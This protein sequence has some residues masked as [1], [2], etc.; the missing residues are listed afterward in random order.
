LLVASDEA[1]SVR[2]W[3]L[4][5]P[6]G[7]PDLRSH[8]PISGKAPTTVACTDDGRL[9]AAQNRERVELYWLDDGRSQGVACSTQ[10]PDSLLARVS[11]L[12][13]R[14]FLLTGTKE[15]GVVALRSTEDLSIVGNLSHEER[16]FSASAS[17]KGDMVACLVRNRIVLWD[18][19][20]P[21]SPVLQGDLGQYSDGVGGA[22]F[23]NEDAFLVLQNGCADIWRISIL[24]PP[25]LVSRVQIEGAQCVDLSPCGQYLA[26]HKPD[27]IQIHDLTSTSRKSPLHVTPHERWA[28]STGVGFIGGRNRLVSFASDGRVVLYQTNL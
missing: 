11:F 13:S 18:V 12:G 14:K 26:S 25:K 9:I 21:A 10:T 16:V 22:G 24:S 15:A 19:R 20:D 1:G 8:L 5:G 28:S 3:C 7:S 17:L 6:Q 4:R 2:V 27:V 23:A